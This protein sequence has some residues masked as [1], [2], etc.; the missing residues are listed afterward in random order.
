MIAR[1]FRIALAASALAAAAFIAPAH[2][3]PS[4]AEKIY[5]DLAKLPAAE[6][7]QKLE[8]GARKEG[9]L[10]FIHTWRNNLWEPH[11]NLFRKKYP[12]LN[13][14]A[15]SMGSQDASELL[16]SEELAG[17]HLTDVMSLAV[18][19]MEG[20]LSRDFAAR[21]PSPANERILPQ[22]RKFIDPDNRWTVF[23][24]S[25]FGISYNPNMIPAD[26]APKQWFDLCKP[27][28]KGEVSFDGPNVRFLVGIHAMFGDEKT[29]E[30]I[31]CIGAN[32]PIQQ[33][34]TIDRYQLMLA[35]DHA[36]QGHNFTYYCYAEKV[37]NPNA[38]CVVVQSAPFLGLAGAMVINRNTLHPYAAALLADWAL[39][40]ESQEYAA[41]NFRGPVALK[42]PYLNDDVQMVVSGLPPK[43]TVD[44]VLGWWS[45]YVGR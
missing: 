44:K 34:T 45:E 30:W 10:S 21:I 1:A 17:K 32:K 11:I 16:I 7:Q 8:E 6:R 40:P 19:D 24:W 36:I 37:K 3:E 35:G 29:Q 31:K 15:S 33:Q 41:K 5:A 23:Y 42:H 13:V 4:A 27:E 25:D 20:I 22:Y 28:Y 14:D 39:S 18:P 38:P 12:F 26:K 9:K 43:E 2:A